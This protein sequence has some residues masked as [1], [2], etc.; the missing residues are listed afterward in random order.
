M[1]HRRDG[2]GQVMS[3]ALFPLDVTLGNLG[4][5]RSENLVSHG[6]RVL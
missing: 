2:I 6:L 1:L 5:I 3:S 4:F